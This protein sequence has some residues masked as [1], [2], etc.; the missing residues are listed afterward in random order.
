MTEAIEQIASR[1]AGET[2]RFDAAAAEQMLRFVE[3]FGHMYRE[4][5]KALEEIARAHNEALLRL[6]MA[7]EARDDDTSV[8]IVRIGF[9]AE[10]L[11]LLVGSTPG[12]ARMLRRAA[13]MHDIGKIG[14][15]DHVLKKAGPLT[16]EEREIIKRHPRI[17]AEIIGNSRVPVFRLAAEVALTHHERFDGMGYPSRLAGHD[18]PLS[19]RIT[20]IVDFYDALTMDRVYRPALTPLK[21]RGM[22]VEQRGKAFDPQIVDTF[23]HHFEQIDALR[24]K[25]TELRPTFADLID[26]P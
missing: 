8:H 1:P 14:T 15:P 2:T 13:P 20:A 5:N 21:A 17:G 7:A 22:L 19:G 18:I 12:F 24:R 23:V 16:E 26:A 3:D 4:R 11:V 6:C 10:A 9:L 25:I